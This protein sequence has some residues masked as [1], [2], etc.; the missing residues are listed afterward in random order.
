MGKKQPYLE[1]L[2]AKA[3]NLKT[4]SESM[5]NQRD[6]TK[7]R[8]DNT[9]RLRNELNK[10]AEELEKVEKEYLAVKRLSD[11]ANGKLDFETYVQAAYFGRVLDAANS[12][13]RLMSQNRYELDRG[14][15]HGDGRRHMGLEL[16]VF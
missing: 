11:A 3:K 10:S 8:L 2:N 13:L 12:R 7:S 1:K 15:E 6:D 4:A 9:I 5:R 14:E 16:K